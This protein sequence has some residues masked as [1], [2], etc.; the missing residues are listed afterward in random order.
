[1]PILLRYLVTQPG[2]SARSSVLL[3]Y[4]Y[5]P[6]K[7]SVV[8]R[9]LAGSFVVVGFLGIFIYRRVKYDNDNDRI[10]LETVGA[11]GGRLLTTDDIF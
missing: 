8:T 7:F 9:R 1:M 11:I 5:V 6:T 2:I 4:Y 3:V 10:E